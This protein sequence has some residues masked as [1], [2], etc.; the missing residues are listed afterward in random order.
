M[1]E[2]KLREYYIEENE[3]LK[4][5]VKAYYCQ[6]YIGFEKNGNPDFINF[7]KNDFGSEEKSK[8]LSAKRHLVEN[9]YDLV[10]NVVC[11]ENIDIVCI[12]PRSKAIS[13]YEKS[14]LQFLGGILQIV[15]KINCDVEVKAWTKDDSIYI[16]RHTDTKT[17]HLSK[18]RHGGGT[19][20]MPYPGITKDTCNISP[21]IKGKK[22][23]LIDDIYTKTIN[24]DEDCIQALYDYGAK[25][26]ILF[27][28]AKT[29][30]KNDYLMNLEDLEDIFS[31]F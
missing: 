3:F 18:S 4:K 29:I 9:F 15:Q 21:E 26:V 13:S 27:T 6:D 12:V 8:I 31:N 30:R 17:T 7:L 19:G 25:D 22:I 16:I 14:Q 10:L 2:I 24:I 11:R 1:N 20:E 28:I 5:K 23:L